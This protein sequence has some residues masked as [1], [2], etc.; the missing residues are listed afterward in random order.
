VIGT[1]GDQWLAEVM[2]TVE[3]KGLVR[4][5]IREF[6][7]DVYCLHQG[8]ELRVGGPNVILNVGF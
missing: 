3:N 8:Q 1:Q 4:H 7:F 2:A 5:E 6:T